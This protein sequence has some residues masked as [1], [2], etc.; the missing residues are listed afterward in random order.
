M[1]EA[2]ASVTVTFA[3]AMVPE[4]KPLPVKDTTVTPGCAE[5]GVA[6]AL[7]VIATGACAIKQTGITNRKKANMLIPE[8]RTH[9]RL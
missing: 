8:L 5:A 9:N 3:G 6:L 2:G 4:G 1:P 7:S